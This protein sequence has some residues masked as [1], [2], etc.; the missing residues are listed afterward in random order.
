VGSW[1]SSSRARAASLAAALL[2]RVALEVEELLEL[3]AQLGERVAQV[4]LAVAAPHLLAQLLEEVVEAHDPDA[5]VPLEP[6]V[7][8][9][10]ERLLHVVRERQVLGELLEDA[11]RLEAD[12]LRAVPGV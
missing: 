11:V 6:L 5:L 1:S 9:P 2:E 4:D 12:L 7:E 8:E 3:L 10:V